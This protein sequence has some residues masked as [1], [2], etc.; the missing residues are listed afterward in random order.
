MYTYNGIKIKIER[1]KVALLEGMPLDES[2]DSLYV[3][4]LALQV[5]GRTQLTHSSTTGHAKSKF[6]QGGLDENL[7]NFMKSKFLY[8]FS[9]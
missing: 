6:T 8:S 9:L 4:G 2:F 5:F 3:G 1:T 7:M